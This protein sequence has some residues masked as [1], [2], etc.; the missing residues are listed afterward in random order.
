[1]DTQTEQNPEI[2]VDS[3]PRN[4]KLGMTLAIF[5]I[6][7]LTFRVGFTLGEKGFQ[8]DAK[9]FKIINQK[10]QPKDVDYSIL[11]DAL[12]IV[13]N[14][15]IDKPVDQ[16][17]VLY[18]AV[19]GAIAAAGDQYTEFF[20]PEDLASFKT[21]LKGSFDG[22][23]AEI[24]KKNGL[25]V[26]VAPLDDS[27]AKKAG[28]LAQDIITAVNGESTSDNTLDDVVKK[29]R[30]PKGTEVTLTIYRSGKSGTFD[31]KIK[32]EN[33][34]IKS[35]KISYKDSNGKKVAVISV[36]RF[37]DDTKTLFDSAVKQVQSSGATGLILDLRNDPGGYLET[38][39]DLASNWIPKNKLIV[40]EAHSD[41]RTNTYNSAGYETLNKFKTVVLIN[42]GSASA[43]EILAGA[44][45]DYNFA[46]LVGQKS[47]GKGS[48]QELIDLAEGG[49]VKV[50]VAKWITPNGKNLNKD[51][52]EPDVKVD[53]TEDDAANNRDPQMDAAITELTK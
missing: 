5:V 49:A 42:G 12:N 8:Y 35:V 6:L 27:P 4:K 16:Q 53:L 1:M 22:I 7:A 32:R 21:E 33:I 11:W 2:N 50:T 3:K 15:Y 38:A 36:S 46:K 25:V 18:G 19:R 43:S 28:I 26:I 31:V 37:G 24:D 48:V 40:S 10:D 20:D 51:G 14:K 30:G 47:F 13:N 45:H 34:Q 44:L 52:L 39:V 23:G 9:T 29:I 17:K 41:G